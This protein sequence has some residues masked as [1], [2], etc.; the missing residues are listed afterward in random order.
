MN[1]W[2]LARV[3]T[4]KWDPEAFRDLLDEILR[5][6]GMTDAEL[7]ELAGRSRS[8]AN[9]WKRAENQP[10]YD[11]LRRLADRLVERDAALVDLARQLL[12]SAGYEPPSTFTES[13][14]D[15]RSPFEVIDGGGRSDPEE[16]DDEAMIADFKAEIFRDTAER[17]IWAL[18]DLPVEARLAA[19]RGKRQGQRDAARQQQTR[20]R[21]EPDL[22]RESN[23][24]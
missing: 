21:A 17:V 1:T 2:Y 19:I 23:G 12:A 11:P 3:R 8:Q 22:P 13:A 20:Y 10:A 15:R 9:R 5:R 18:V 4:P 16:D 24:R 14:D 6:T 7:G